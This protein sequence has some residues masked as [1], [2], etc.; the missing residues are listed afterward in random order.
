MLHINVFIQYCVHLTYYL[1]Y[2]IFHQLTFL[3]H[4]CSFYMPYICI[5]LE[6]KTEIHDFHV[7]QNEIY[8]LKF[9]DFIRE[10]NI[11][12]VECR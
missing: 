10:F 4:K 1:L 12:N 8:L 5:C 2:N 9:A 11:P 6:K 3:W 7:F